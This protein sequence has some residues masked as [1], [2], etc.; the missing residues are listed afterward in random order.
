MKQIIIAS[1]TVE[2]AR[3]NIKN[4]HLAVNPPIGRVSI[5]A[6]LQVSDDVIRRLVISKL[7]WIRRNQRNFENQER[8]SPRE[9][10]EKESHYFQGRRYLLRIN[11]TEKSGWVDLKGK[12]Y[13]DMYV[14]NNASLEYK[15]KVLNEWYRKELKKLL[16][17]MIKFWE[18][19]IGIKVDFWGVKQMKTKWGSCNIEKK[20][21]WLNLELAKKPIRSLKYILVHEM[22]HLLERHHNDKFKKHMHRYMPWWRQLKDELNKMPL[23]HAEWKDTNFNLRINFK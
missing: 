4:I 5:A 19:K 20:R 15:Q 1:V 6:P 21:I 8:F 16:P 9:Y 14:N 18:N 7:G 23:S 11:E 17:E 13:L 12:I 3:K 2:V 22:V 10:K